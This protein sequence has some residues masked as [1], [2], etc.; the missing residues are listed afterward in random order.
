MSATKRILI[1]PG[2]PAGIG[3]DITIQMAQEDWAHELVVI[4]D[5][6][7]LTARAK[8]LNL[9]LQLNV[10]DLHAAPTPS[11]SGALK[12]IPVFL[13][14]HVIAG[15]LNLKNADYVLRTLEEAA[16]LCQNKMAP[17]VVTGPVNKAILNDAGIKFTGHTEF[18]A[19]YCHVSNTVMLFVIDELK[20]A[21]TTTHLPLIDVSPAITPERLRLTIA[22][23]VDGLKKQFHINSPRVLICG[24][25]PHAGEGGHLGHEEIDIISPTLTTL[26][27]E[28]YH[29]YGPLPADTIFTPKYLK[30]ADAVLAMYH[31][32][33]LPLVKY[34][35]FGN[36]VNVTLGLPFIRTSV[37]HG[38]ALAIAGTGASNPASMKAATTL[39]IKLL[40][41]T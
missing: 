29:L 3:P 8:Q 22:T 18:F 23:L 24:L 40:L 36:A 28:G 16:E 38:T 33:A 19:E 15:E 6:V 27:K 1:T 25:N 12:I 13:N 35:G 9:A 2:E 20:V 30:Q 4:A 17:A 10:I 32:Q 31:D 5:P 11:L 37:D 7:L 41:E 39:A 21:L 26:R 34:L 14:G